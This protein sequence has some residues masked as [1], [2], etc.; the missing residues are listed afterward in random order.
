MSALYLDNAA[1][2]RVLPEVAAV[3]LRAATETYANPSSVHGPGA[4]ARRVVED[5][6]GHV[7]TALGVEPAELIFTS[8]GTEANNLAIRGLPGLRP[9]QEAVI[10]AVEH[11]SVYAQAEWLSERGLEVHLAPVDRHGVTDISALDA[12]LNERTKLVAVMAVNNETG[13]VQPIPEIVA[14]AREKAPSARVHCDVVQAFCKLPTPVRAWGLDSASCTAHKIHGPKGIGALYLRAGLSLHQRVGG[15]SQE[16]R[17]R[18]GTENVPGIAAF[19]AAVAW[20]SPRREAVAKKVEAA[21]AR[22]FDRLPS[23][24]PG[25]E[26]LV[27]Q[28]RAA[29]HIL[30]VSVPGCRSETLLHFL[31]REGVCVSSGSA[32]HADSVE[33]SHVLKALG[34]TEDPGSFRAS[35]GADTPDDALDRLLDALAR[36]VGQVR[37]ICAR[38][39]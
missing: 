19:G 23:A 11:P 13:S 33:L 8:G 30:A 25:A 16:Q 14:R 1:T 22:F 38:A 37:E 36:V 34:L 3:L 18:P 15:G 7:A 4:D 9:G 21:R 35:I 10:S 27:D 2:T 24:V 26:P 32:C 6:R 5:A 12:L 28:R 39:R 29:H 20:M 31:E 17:I